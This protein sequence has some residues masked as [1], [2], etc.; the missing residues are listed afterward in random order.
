MASLPRII[1]VDPTGSIPQQIR[2]AFDL[3]DRLVVQIDVPDPTEA[4][5]ELERGGIDTVIAAWNLGNGTQGWELAAKLRQVD[6]NVKIMLLGDYDDT[7]LDEEM[8]EQSPF[9]YL[10][11]PFNIPQL[12]KVL[13]AALDGRDIFAAVNARTEPAPST[14]VNLGPVPNVNA[15]KADEIMQAVIYDMNP[16]AAMLATRDGE[17]V[18][19]RTTMGDV[20][21]DYM[22]SLIGSTAKMNIDMRDVIGGNLQTLQ[23]YDGSDYDVFVLS[24]G[25]HH[26]L[27]IIFDGKDGAAQIG[28]VRRFGSKHAEN[29][30]AVIGPG[31][32]FVHR[33]APEPKP[34]DV[35][36]KSEHAKKLATQET[37][38]PELARAE[39]GT[40][41][42]DA[43]NENTNPVVESSVPQLE[44]IAD[45][46]FDADLLFGGDFD[47][48]SADDLFSLDALEDLII[49][50]NKKG[51]TDWDGAMQLG[52]IEDN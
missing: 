11:R 45:D 42:T 13:E 18:V 25:L 7:E 19:G 2:A 32:F 27:T 33:N 15:D 40:S 36:R 24:V 14:T 17:I 10:K 20:D 4:L 43:V 37:R 1:T 26:F 44:A 34:E 16:L 30:I 8:R 6:E 31:A 51:T 41:E 49:D 28:A 22:A 29:L 48:D 39:L 52:I 46:A 9:V 35:R 38:I 12:I 5:N 3:M 50:D 21:Y 47:E 23:L